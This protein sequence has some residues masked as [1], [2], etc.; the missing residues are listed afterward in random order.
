MSMEGIAARAGVGK[1]T[2][3]RR[4]DSKEEVVISA[5]ETV[6]AE[7][8][9]RPP[10]TGN[11]RDDLIALVQ[12]FRQAA[13]ESALAPA[14]PHVIGA[15]IT[16][17]QLLAIFR[18]RLVEPRQST[19]R[20]ILQRGIERGDVRPDIDVDLIVDMIPGTIFFQILIKQNP[21]GTPPS[22]ELIERLVDSVWRGIAVDP[23]SHIHND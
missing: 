17:P 15:A 23:D 12:G 11:T 4:W 9:Y 5:L 10:D 1:T 20:T 14:A 8:D 6:K 7:T 2:I 18:E 21:D 16:S 13:A 22:R 19:M 3:Y